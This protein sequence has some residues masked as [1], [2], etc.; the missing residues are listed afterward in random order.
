ME[1]SLTSSRPYLLR[2]LHEW[3]S[4]NGQ[5]PLIMVDTTLPGVQVPTGFEKDGR[6][7]LNIADSATG[8]LHLGNDSVSFSARFNGAAHRVSVPIDAILSVV[9]R[10]TGAGMTFEVEGTALDSDAS[11]NADEADGVDSIPSQDSADDG[12]EPRPT[13]PNGPGLRLVK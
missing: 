7:I 6:V 12:P 13:R 3:I 9:S 8:Q 1:Q 10:E 11:N 4:D 2:A 5:T